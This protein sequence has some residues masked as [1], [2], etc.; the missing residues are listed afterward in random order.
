[1]LHPSVRE[2]RPTAPRQRPGVGEKTVAPEMALDTPFWGLA[3]PA[4]EK[5][6]GLEIVAEIYP[7]GRRPDG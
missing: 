3:P 2:A 4:L 5:A 7:V 6:Q 1:M